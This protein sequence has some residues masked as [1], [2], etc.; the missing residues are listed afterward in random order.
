MPQFRKPVRPN[1]SAKP[2][3]KPNSKSGSSFGHDELPSRIAEI[4]N[5]LDFV[6][7]DASDVVKREVLFGTQRK[8]KLLIVFTEGLVDKVELENHIL[9][10]VLFESRLTPPD[11]ASPSQAFEFLESALVS[12]ASAQRVDTLDEVILAVLS[13]VSAIFVDGHNQ[14]LLFETKGWPSRGVSE[15]AV[16]NVIRGP[17]DAFTETLRMNTALIRRRWRDPNIVFEPL[18]LGR[19]SKT[20]VAIV[21]IDDLV[22]KNLLTEVRRRL[23]E[24]DIDLVLESGYVEQLIEDSAYSPFPTCQTT[25]RPDSVVGAISEGRVGII[26]DGTPL[27]LLVPTTIN[28]LMQSAEDYYN[29]WYASSVSRLVRFVGNLLALV[30]PGLYIA[31]TSFHPEMLPTDLAKSIASSR[32]GVPFPAFIEAFVMQGALE[33]LQ[34][35]GV[36]LPSAIGQTIGIVGGLIVGEAAV[37][38]G[39][40]SPGIV[41]VIALTGISTF[42]IPSYPLATAFRLLRFA[43]MLGAAFLGLFGLVAAAWLIL[44]HLMSIK[45]FGVPYVT[46]W[47]PFS[48]SD[49]KDTIVRLPTQAFR[50]RPMT[51]SSS[52]ATRQV[53]QRKDG[54]EGGNDQ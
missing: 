12:T 43:L 53:S 31:L 4:K 33:L 8:H 34:E 27:V 5:Q 39:L 51:Y 38:A 40:V 22:D 18:K 6:F 44:V 15:P 7:K 2:A 48:L 10:P 21:Y 11:Y 54:A 26:V 35:A 17:R 25:E 24:I 16:E 37:S 50:R 1:S 23:S 29:R 19:R 42:A 47:A 46:P 20:D 52:D 41:I 9:K 14:A 3:S 32:V 49:L 45:S 36:R 30:L 28:T 13:G